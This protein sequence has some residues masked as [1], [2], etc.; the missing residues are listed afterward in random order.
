MLRWVGR[1]VAEVAQP[2]IPKE[3]RGLLH[4]IS[5][6]WA[7]IANCWLN[8][9]PAADNA[10]EPVKERDVRKVLVRIYGDGVELFFDCEDE[11]RTFEC[12]SCHGQGPRLLGYFPNGCVEEFIHARVRSSPRSTHGKRKLVDGLPVVARTMES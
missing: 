6:S 8:D 2:R 10:G 5:A 1:S 12:M 4:E 3:A 7:D 9:A 11:V